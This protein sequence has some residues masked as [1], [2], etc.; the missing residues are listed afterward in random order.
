MFYLC[1]DKFPCVFKSV[2]SPLSLSVCCVFAM[3]LCLMFPCVIP[4]CHPSPHVFLDA[5]FEIGF[6]I[7][8][9]LICWICL[10]FV[11]SV[12]GIDLRL[13]KTRELPTA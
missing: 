7:F 12:H 6:W 11:K 3:C 8:A 10:R 9:S 1:L 13:P 4:V 5:A 2:W